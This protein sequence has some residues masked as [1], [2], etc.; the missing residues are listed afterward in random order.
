MDTWDFARFA[1]TTDEPDHEGDLESYDMGEQLLAAQLPRLAEIHVETDTGRWGFS[2]V[3]RFDH[4]L[5]GERLTE[6]GRFGVRFGDNLY[7]WGNQGSPRL[8]D[9]EAFIRFVLETADPREIPELLA[10]VFPDYSVRK[11][12]VEA[13]GER[14]GLTRAG[15]VA[16]FLTRKPRAEKRLSVMPVI[17][18]PAYWQA[19]ADGEWIPQPERKE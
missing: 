6:A 2:R 11:T 1:T 4:R 3:Q 18:A 14:L 5:I 9:T 15:A 12:G 17:K 10:A 16:R 8:R 13:V 19:I 7:L